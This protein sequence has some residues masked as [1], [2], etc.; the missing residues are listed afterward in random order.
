LAALFLSIVLSAA[1]VLSVVTSLVMSGGISFRRSLP[2]TQEA[3][4]TAA[5]SPGISK[6]REP[7]ARTFV[8]LNIT[9]HILGHPLKSPG[10]RAHL[11]AAILFRNIFARIFLPRWMRYH[12]FYPYI[13]GRSRTPHSL[14]WVLS[15]HI[16]RVISVASFFFKFWHLAH[17]ILSEVGWDSVLAA[18]VLLLLFIS[19]RSRSV[20]YAALM[21]PFV[22]FR[23][24]VEPSWRRVRSVYAAVAS[25]A[26]APF[27]RVIPQS[28]ENAVITEPDPAA[29][30]EVSTTDDM[31]DETALH[32]SVLQDE[33]AAT[34]V[35]STCG[36]IVEGEMVPQAF[37]LPGHGAV[38]TAVSTCRGIVQTLR[39]RNVSE[40]E[41]EDWCVI[42]GLHGSSY[43][44]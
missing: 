10:W 20:G 16:S 24:K 41:K 7:L 12:P 35:V 5:E 40:E 27:F 8:A 36:G 26:G 33:G 38:T 18:C 37:V 34:T 44:L 1:F 43:G 30:V 4:P 25:L 6:Y 11:I 15:R 23:A 28:Q 31:R 19:P 21:V 29:N 42:S 39:A 22:F 2:E 3:I 13:F 14:K 32:A 9:A 17:R